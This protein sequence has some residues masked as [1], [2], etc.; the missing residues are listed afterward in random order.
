MGRACPFNPK[1]QPALS[2]HQSPFLC[3]FG[4]LPEE[5]IDAPLPSAM[6]ARSYKKP[7]LID[8][9]RYHATFGDV[10]IK[11][12]KRCLRDLKIPQQYRYE[13][14]IDGKIDIFGHKAFKKGERT[15]YLTGT[16]IDTD[17]SGHLCSFSDSS[18]VLAA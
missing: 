1:P 10:G 16:K 12:T 14:Y 4:D 7:S 11:C 2:E 15:E 13:S 3:N 17:H 6:L 5:I 9:D 8:I 18:L